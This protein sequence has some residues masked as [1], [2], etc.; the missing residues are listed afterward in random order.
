MH[1]ANQ[2]ILTKTWKLTRLEVGHLFYWRCG[3]RRPS[4]GL[5]NEALHIALSLHCSCNFLLEVG[6]DSGRNIIA[7][8]GESSKNE[9]QSK[10]WGHS[11][12][13]RAR[14]RVSSALQG[15]PILRNAP[16]SAGGVHGP[17]T[18][19]AGLI[20]VAN[21]KIRKCSLDPQVNTGSYS[22]TS[23]EDWVIY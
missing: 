10:W 20:H 6:R 22:S 5:N 23:T 18:N 9:L 13:Q 1:I 4:Y 14:V 21:W 17:H 8:K 7:R 15:A 11:T 3:Q 2:L 16:T 12:I 19:I